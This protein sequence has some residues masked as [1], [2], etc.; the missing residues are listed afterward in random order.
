MLLTAYTEMEMVIEAINKGNI[1]RYITKPYDVADLRCA[2]LQDR[3]LL[4]DP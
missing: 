1:Y 4:P 3:A 2:M